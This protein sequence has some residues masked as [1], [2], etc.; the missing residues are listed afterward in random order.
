MS[1]EHVDKVE[2]ESCA[3]MTP[4]MIVEQV[5]SHLPDFKSTGP[6]VRL[7]GGY[8]NYVYRVPGQPQS[9]VVK[10]APPHI[11]AMPDV[12]L[13]PGRIIFEGRS[14]AAFMP[15]GTMEACTTPKVRPPHLL[16]FEEDQC[17]LVEEDVGQVP[18]LGKWL[19]TGPYREWPGLRVGELLGEFIG[20]LHLHS[21]GDAHLARAFDNKTIQHSRLEV[22]YKMVGMMLARGGVADAGQLG[23]RAVQLGELLQEPGLC[24]I[25][26]DLWLPSI[27]VA[28]DGL[29]VI[30]W[31]LVHFGRPSQDVGHLASHLWMWSH[32]A[33]SEA[34]AEETRA[35][36]K[37]FLR[38][39]REMLGT[40]FDELFGADGVYESSVHFGSEILMRTTG[41]FQEGY[42]YEGLPS[43]GPV[44]Q[45]ALRVAAEHIRTPEA[46]D[47]FA[48]LED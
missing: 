31:E 46:V 19:Q 34:V 26:G 40:T 38:A 30:D 24:F 1:E 9:V 33:S 36:L 39:Y 13:D 21:Y 5:R 41:P 14:L 22:H 23:Q 45:E 18:H 15:G 10:C 11:A 29:R 27:L 3:Q 47:T 6:P 28:P 20:G 43:D 7:T 32:R 12:P 2:S 17:L 35:V 8:L 44:V 25:Q 37:G 16:Y 42:L 48:L 4:A